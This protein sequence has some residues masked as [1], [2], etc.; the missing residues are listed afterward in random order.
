VYIAL[1]A[2]GVPLFT[3]AGGGLL[4]FA[5]PTAGYLFGFIAATFIIGTFTRNE[6]CGL[7]RIFGITCLADCVLLLCGSLWLSL[8]LGCSFTK[9]LLIGA[10]PF[11]AGDLLKCWVAAQVFLASKKIGR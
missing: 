5:G 4:Y 11:V 3:L 2:A 6:K 7:W 1:G 10:A 8:F 9:A